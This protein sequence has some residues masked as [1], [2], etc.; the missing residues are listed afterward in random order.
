MASTP[1]TITVTIQVPADLKFAR[2]AAEVGA[3]CESRLATMLAQVAGAVLRAHDADPLVR[4]D[5]A[6]RSA[7]VAARSSTLYP[8]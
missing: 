3:E 5:S 2:D 8:L 6:T 7:N 1:R 4:L